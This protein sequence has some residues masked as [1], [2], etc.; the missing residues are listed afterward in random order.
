MAQ[1]IYQVDAFTDRPFSGNPAGV[2]ILDAPRPEAWMQDVAR[3]MNLSETAFLHPIDD[4][5]YGLR[6][7]TPALEVDLCGHATLASAH[8]LWQTD[9]LQPSQQARFE[10]RT[11]LLT[12]NLQG[13]WIQLD[14]PSTPALPVE[15]PPGLLE[16]LGVRALTVG[17]SRF[18]YLVEVATEAE[19]RA[20][21]PDFGRLF[22][23]EARGVILT[24]PS[25]MP[26]YDFVSRFF[27]PAAG[28]DEDPVTG[29]AHCCLAPFWSERLGKSEMVA[30]QASARGGT[31]RVSVAKEDRVLISGQA[32]TVMRCELQ[33]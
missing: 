27:A 30:Y 29:S 23:V 12:A 33:V 1:T 4:G 2:C 9:L 3:E 15:A 5:A 6:W 13:D 21:S 17:H 16:S 32:V 31:L 28:I 20:T 24:A 26:G 22:A 14:F 18:D 25:S 11:G 10:T 19:V 8:I 7:F